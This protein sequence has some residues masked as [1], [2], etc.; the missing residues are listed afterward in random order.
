MQGRDADRVVVCAVGADG[1]IIPFAQ[2]EGGRWQAPSPLIRETTLEV[3]AYIHD[4]RSGGFVNT[5][6]PIHV[7]IAGQAYVLPEPD[8]QLAAVIL[9]EIYAKDGVWRAKISNEGFTFGIEA[10]ARARNLRDVQFPSRPGRNPDRPPRGATASGSGVLIAPGLVITNAHVIEDGTALEL[11]RSRNK[12]KPVAADLMHDLALL[13]GE[14]DGDPLPLRNTAPLWLGEGVLAAG[15]PLMDVLGAD[16][17]VTTGNISGLTGSHGDVSRFQFTAP[18]GSGSSG[19]A[20]IDEFGNLVGVTC[21]S[22][23]HG[24]MRERGSISENVNF[25]VR[26]ALVYELV[27]AAGFTLPDL[28]PSLNNDRRDVVQRLRKSVVSVIVHF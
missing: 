23:A 26:V 15:F 7:E 10:Y 21:S 18:I 16:L 17:K 9:T 4:D 8:Q 1:G 12:L 19:G 22:L 3:V 5:A 2:G 13:E 24:N 20:I 14:V 11:G 28:K 6:Y 25:A 27:A